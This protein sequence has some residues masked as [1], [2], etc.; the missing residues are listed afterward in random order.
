[1]EKTTFSTRLPEDTLRTLRLLAAYRKE[2]IGAIVDAALR[3]YFGLK[4]EHG[5]WWVETYRAVEKQKRRKARG[6][7]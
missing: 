6:R 5:A 3:R 7:N 1:M 2:K 4:S